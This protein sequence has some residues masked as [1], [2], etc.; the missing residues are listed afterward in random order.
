M[1]HP[2]KNSWTPE[3]LARLTEL[4]ERGASVLRAAAALNRKTTVIQKKARELR[5]SLAGVRK[6]RSDLRAAGITDTQ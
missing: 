3:E 2:T 5:I 4:A 6:V 1:P